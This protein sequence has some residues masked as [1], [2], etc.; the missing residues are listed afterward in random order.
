MS[1]I[2]KIRGK[3]IV[4]PDDNIDTDR[5]IPARFLRCLTFRELGPHVFKDDRAAAKAQGQI[6]PFDEPRYQGAGVLITGTNFGSGSSREHAVHALARWGIKAIISY[7]DYSEIFFG[8]SL[9]NGLPCLIINKSNWQDLVEFVEHDPSQNLEIDLSK[10]TLKIG[11]K[12]IKLSFQHQEAQASFLDGSWD[13][14]GTLMEAKDLVD[15]R[16]TSLPYVTN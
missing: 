13:K 6:H 10:M 7:G 1:N 11:F 5:I 12:F 9:A 14:I 16:I 2:I 15:E 3:A 8:N 4:L